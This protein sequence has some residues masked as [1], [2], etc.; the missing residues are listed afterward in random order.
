MVRLSGSS[1]GQAADL[2]RLLSA[3]QE[4]D[5]YAATAVFVVSTGEQATVAVTGGTVQRESIQA[6]LITAPK[7]LRTI[8]WLLGLRPMTQSESAATPLTHLF[9]RSP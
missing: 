3:L 1:D 7:V 5:E 9:E 4:H 6:E 8:T 2:G